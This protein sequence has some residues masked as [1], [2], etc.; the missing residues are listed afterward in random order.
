MLREKNTVGLAG[1][2]GWSGV[3]GNYCSA[4]RPTEHSDYRPNVENFPFHHQAD[5]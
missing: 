5:W 1:A 2:G 3:R 4:G